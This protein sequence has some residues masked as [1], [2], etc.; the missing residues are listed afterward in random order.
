M[1]HIDFEKRIMKFRS[2][3]EDAIKQ[4][5]KDRIGEDGYATIGDG[6]DGAVIWRDDYDNYSDTPYHEMVSIVKA[7]IKDDRVILKAND[8]SEYAFCNFDIYSLIGLY[9]T[10][11]GV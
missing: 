10:I 6:V 8:E 1:E 5:I 7:A 9:N 4:E 11:I 2:E 3:I